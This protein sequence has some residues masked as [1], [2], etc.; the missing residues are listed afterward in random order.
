[1]ITVEREIFAA[2]DYHDL[3]LKITLANIIFVMDHGVTLVAPVEAQFVA[4]KFCGK[5]N[6]TN[7]TCGRKFPFYS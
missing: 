1:M 5:K 2:I 3:V 6:K 4:V 7:P